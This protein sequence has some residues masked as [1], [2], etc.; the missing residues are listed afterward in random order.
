MRFPQGIPE[1]RSTVP[2]IQRVRGGRRIFLQ[3]KTCV[4]VSAAC[5]AELV[6]YHCCL[7]RGSAGPLP[8]H[9]PHS[10]QSILPCT[11]TPGGGGGIHPGLRRKA[12]SALPAGTAA[13]PP[14]AQPVP[15]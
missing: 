4:F 3:S 12:A 14:A 9:P 13:L 1:P 15:R 10:P 7:L 11:Q 5:R 8:E 2:P 6:P